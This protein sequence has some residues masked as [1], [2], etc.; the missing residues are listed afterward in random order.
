MYAQQSHQH[1]SIHA[2]TFVP[3]KREK[4]SGDLAV[5]V[6]LVVVVMRLAKN[7]KFELSEDKP[8]TVHLPIN[9]PLAGGDD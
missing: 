9:S 2:Q 7:L 5:L 3:G 6:V 8:S 1:L 4:K